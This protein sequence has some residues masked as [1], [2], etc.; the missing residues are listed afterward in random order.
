MSFPK[1]FID[2]AMFCS[3]VLYFSLSHMV[4]DG[5]MRFLPYVGTKKQ[6]G[7]HAVEKARKTRRQLGQ[8]GMQTSTQA[9]NQKTDRRTDGQTYA[10]RQTHTHTDRRKHTG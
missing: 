2:F 10:H 1:V 7:G 3:V 4:C 9:G 5:F 8:E 6:A